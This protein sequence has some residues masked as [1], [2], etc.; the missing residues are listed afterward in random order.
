MRAE[1]ERV[2]ARYGQRVLLTGKDGGERTVRAFLQPVLKRREKLP[3]TATPLGAVSDARWLYIGSG[4][5]PVAPG[6]RVDCGGLRLTVQEARA[7]C[8]EDTPCY[9]W[10]ILRPRKEAAAQ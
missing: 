7:V 8:W 4:R 3:V 9:H 5:Q 10:A 6:D 1:F 2:L